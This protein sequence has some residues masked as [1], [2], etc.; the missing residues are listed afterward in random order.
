MTCSDSSPPTLLAGPSSV[1]ASVNSKVTFSCTISNANI[2]VWYVNGFS[3]NTVRNLV[4][5]DAKPVCV[6]ECVNDAYVYNITFTIEEDVDLN[7]LNNSGISCA[8]VQESADQFSNRSLPALLL[9]QG[10]H[11]S[12]MSLIS[13]IYAAIYYKGSNLVAKVVSSTSGS[14]AQHTDAKSSVSL[15]CSYRF[16]DFTHTFT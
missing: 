3:I 13:Y 15:I 1:N 8:G 7:Q 6:D 10:E 5:Q 16:I 2:A 4:V 14:Q 12:T 11:S 9:I